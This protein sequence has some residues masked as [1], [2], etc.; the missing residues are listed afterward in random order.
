MFNKKTNPNV[1][2]L[3]EIIDIVNTELKTTDPS[4]A[5]YSK[6]LDHL[7]TLHKIANDDNTS[8]VRVSPDT[9]A[10]IAGHLAGIALIVK[11]EETHV[12]ASKAVSFVQKLR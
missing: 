2:A 7:S 10:N 9:W 3:N 5:E 12:L 4:S 1:D 8:R 6:L 11:Y